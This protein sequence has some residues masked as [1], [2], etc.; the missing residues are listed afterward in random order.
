MA[1][2]WTILMRTWRRTGKDNLFGLAAG[3]AA[4]VSLYDL[5]ADPKIVKQVT[6]M[7]G[8]LPPEAVK[9]VA[10][11]LQTLVRGPPVRFNIGVVVSV[12][13]ALWSSWSAAGMLMVAVNACY[14]K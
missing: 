4:V 3:V 12:L 6:S 7:E 10:N 2:L 11:W 8:L 9:L 1:V 5:A 13:V 14:E